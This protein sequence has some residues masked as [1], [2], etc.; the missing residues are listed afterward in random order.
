MFATKISPLKHPILDAFRTW[1]VEVW[2]VAHVSHE[3]LVSVGVQ[4][5]GGI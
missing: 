1:S 4:G 2:H 3:D 5:D